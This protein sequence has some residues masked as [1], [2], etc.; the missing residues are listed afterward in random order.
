MISGTIGMFNLDKMYNSNLVLFILKRHEKSVICF[1]G[2]FNQIFLS[3]C[4]KIHIIKCFTDR[5]S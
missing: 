4:S 1:G 5:H 3:S 2:I